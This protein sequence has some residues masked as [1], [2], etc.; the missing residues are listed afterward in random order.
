MVDN[1]EFAEKELVKNNFVK[2]FTALMTKYH[3]EKLDS[4][5]KFTDFDFSA[6]KD[7]LLRESEIRKARSTEEK[8]I[9]KEDKLRKENYYNFRPFIK[10]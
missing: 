4:D 1:N 7:H 2:S 3:G 5:L 6:I 9:E 8:N 10:P